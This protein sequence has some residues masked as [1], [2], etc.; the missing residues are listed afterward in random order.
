MTTNEINV[1]EDNDIDDNPKLKLIIISKKGKL[2][3]SGEGRII[4]LRK[5]EGR[6]ELRMDNISENINRKKIEKTL[7]SIIYNKS[8]SEMKSKNKKFF[9]SNKNKSNTLSEREL[10]IKKNSENNKNCS[11][12]DDIY[13]KQRQKSFEE[14]VSNKNLKSIKEKID[15]INENNDIIENNEITKYNNISNNNVINNETKSFNIDDNNDNNNTIKDEIFL[16]NDKNN[17]KMKEINEYI[18]EENNTNKNKEINIKTTEDLIIKNNNLNKK[19]IN[20]EPS[21]L[22]NNNKNKYRELLKRDSLTNDEDEDEEEECDEEII[23]HNDEHNNNKN[24]NANKKISSPRDY[25]S[26]KAIKNELSERD[27]KYIIS[28]CNDGTNNFNNFF[29]NNINITINNNNL[30]KIINLNSI[31]NIEKESKNYNTIDEVNNMVLQKKISNITNKTNSTKINENNNNKVEKKKTSLYSHNSI[32][33]NK[34]E[35]SKESRNR[36]FQSTFSV[37]KNFMPIHQMNPVY[38]T[39]SICDNTY[40]SSKI[41]VPECGIHFLCKRCAK[42]YYEEKIENGHS[43]LKC[44][45]LYCQT[46]FPKNILKNLVSEEH[47][48]LLNENNYK[49]KV[50]SAK[51]KSNINYEDMKV[52]S[53]N[54]VIDINNNKILYNYN[55]SRDIFCSKCNKDTLFSKVNNYFLKCLNCGHCECKFCFKDYH[56]GH[57]DINNQNRCKVYFRRN[58]DN[59]GI[60]KFYFFLIQLFLVFAIYFMIFISIFLNSKEFLKS[61]LCISNKKKR[62]NFFIYY[63]KMFFVIIFSTIILLI[64]FPFIIVWFPFFPSLLSMSD[65]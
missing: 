11:I 7:Q 2:D 13:L 15:I 16:I 30:E 26:N 60:N 1:K 48:H 37:N 6:M 35:N 64:T 52:Y 23:S 65:Y 61:I 59:I 44:P 33:D 49:N 38:K 3:K 10:Y 21:N 55:K 25:D 34:N 57:M 43:D 40:P 56:N 47:Y 51:L 18:N 27:N 32:N 53:Q 20:T 22:N 28:S 62:Y 8:V 14:K 5:D 63:F 19:E 58:D 4:T 46:K 12:Y 39:C 42:N 54:H 36:T 50:I 41:F 29:R 9:I 31:T 17:D 24:N 45:F